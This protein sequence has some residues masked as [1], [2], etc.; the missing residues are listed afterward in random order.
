MRDS[1]MKKQFTAD[2]IR[3]NASMVSIELGK[4]KTVAPRYEEDDD[5]LLLSNVVITEQGT[6]EKLPIVD[7]VLVDAEGKKHYFFCTGRIL[8]SI[9]SMVQGVNYKNHG[10]TN[11]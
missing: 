2:Q 11:P 8:Q 9:A 3:A 7:F 1:E 10:N 5:H 6:V 4:D